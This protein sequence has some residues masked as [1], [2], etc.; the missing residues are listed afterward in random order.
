ME[1]EM[2]VSPDSIFFFAAPP[3]RLLELLRG[4]GLDFQEEAVPCG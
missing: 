4:L 1:V 3:R 2:M